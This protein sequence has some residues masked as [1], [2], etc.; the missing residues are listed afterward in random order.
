MFYNMILHTIAH[1]IKN[2]I[3]WFGGFFQDQKQSASSKR[4]FLY[5]LAFEWHY[6][7]KAY[8]A[9]LPMDALFLKSFTLLTLVCLGVITSEF[10]KNPKSLI[11]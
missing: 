11:P 9:N 3:I 5:F 6:V 8:C 2:F 4:A 1:E 10:F 7:V